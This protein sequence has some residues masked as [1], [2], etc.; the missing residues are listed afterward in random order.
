MGNL[1]VSVSELQLIAGEIEY[2]GLYLAKL[3]TK[4]KKTNKMLFQ[5]NS[6][7]YRVSTAYLL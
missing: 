4:Q 7:E 6:T 5:R 2:A 1:Q 3:K